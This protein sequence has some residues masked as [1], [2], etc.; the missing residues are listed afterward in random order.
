MG[1]TTRRTGT[2]EHVE[3]IEGAEPEVVND[4]IAAD[5]TDVTDVTE[6]EGAGSS[7]ED[8]N[9]GTE[10]GDVDDSAEDTGTADPGSTEGD[11]TDGES[12]G[13]DQ[14][15]PTLAELTAQMRDALN[16]A[17]MDEVTRL[18]A[19]IEGY[20][21]P[22]AEPRPKGRTD[23]LVKRQVSQ[24]IVDTLSAN[25]DTLVAGPADEPYTDHEREVAAAKIANI[26]GYLP[27]ASKLVWPANFPPRTGRGL[28]RQVRADS[29]DAE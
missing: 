18:F 23:Q 14:P 20:Q 27:N 12:E 1:R 19:L 21:P 15:A 3:D 4:A 11:S 28:G 5:D 2:D 7:A 22:A 6:P 17:D 8:V 13:D 29:N 25:F 9:E 24:A 26:C 10:P 16:R